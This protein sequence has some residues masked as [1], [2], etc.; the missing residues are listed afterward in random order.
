MRRRVAIGGLVALSLVVLAGILAYPT[1]PNYDSQYALLWA[2]EILDGGAPSFDAY[3]APTEHP[4]ALLASVV[5][6]AI[7]AAPPQAYV[8][9]TLATFV[10]FVGGLVRLG[11]ASLGLVAGLVAA[12]LLLTR[13]NFAF[14]AAFG[15]VDIP[16]L[17]LLVSAA[18]IVA[19]DIVAGAPRSR[20]AVWIMLVAAGLLRPEGWAFAALYAAWAWRA[21]DRR[22]RLQALL[23]VAAAPLLWALTDLVMTGEP[24]F[25]WTYTAGSAAELGRTRG[26]RDLPREAVTSALEY[27][28]LPVLALGLAG[29]ALALWRAPRR[30]AVPLALAAGGVVTFLGLSS[31]GYSVIPRYFSA[32]AVGLFLFAGYALGGWE[33]LPRGAPARQ[34]W[35]RGAALGVLAGGAFVAA[36]L[37]PAKVVADLRL[38]ERV[39]A[40]VDRV[41]AAPAVRAAR[42][43][44][45]I[46]LPNHKLVPYIRWRL[47][48]GRAGVI[49]R[50]DRHD[51]ARARRGGVA[52]VV[53]DVPVIRSHPAFGP[54]TGLDPVTVIPAPP[55]FELAAS[56]SAIT[57][58]TRCAGGS[59]GA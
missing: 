38:R 1:Q 15:Y 46:S 21:V 50:S 43:C 33:H 13:L 5:L 42:A 47:R 52:I 59:R 39:F 37:N 57:A 18:A 12:A 51:A 2:R 16:Y 14:L 6:V 23:G 4:L 17:A 11:A 48:L 22:A 10:A 44:G 19:D 24:L 20:P 31:Q 29:I 30:A 9:V 54:H 27:V 3:R 53:R 41:L 32:A 26:L 7:G 49:A 34:R 35:M 36:T 25:S 28:K 40:D 45:P 58:W 8:A 56:T 55:G